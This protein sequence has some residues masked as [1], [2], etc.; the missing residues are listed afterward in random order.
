VYRDAGNMLVK[1][2][3]SMRLPNC[4]AIKSALIPLME[5]PSPE[6]YYLHLGALS[7]LD[8]AGLG[9]LVG[10]HM[11]ARNRKVQLRI[12]SPTA[13][14][15]KLFESTKLN[16]VLTIMTGVEAEGIRAQ[17]EQEK[18]LIA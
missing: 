5:A 13:F 1:L 8:S 16:A 17:M 3:G 14:I 2:G 6:T 12:L 15:A 18:N 7:E 11:T 10:L 9:V 4:D